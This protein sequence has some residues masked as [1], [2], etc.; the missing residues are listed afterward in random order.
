MNRHLKAPFVRSLLGI[1]LASK[2]LIVLNSCGVE[3]GNPSTKNPKP[4]SVD[5]VALIQD[6]QLTSSF[7]NASHGD[8]VAA[9]VDQASSASS[10]NF[11]LTDSDND[12]S[13]VDKSCAQS[14]DGRAA[15]V[16]VS[17][18]IDRS[19]TKSH[20]GGRVTISA[21]RTGTSNATRTWSRVDGTPVACNSNGSGANVNFK[22]IPNLK[23]NIAFERK[24]IDMITYDGPRVKRTASK[25]FTSSGNRSVTWI[26]NSSNE[27]TPTYIRS[28]SVAIR[29]VKQSLSMTNKN[30]ETFATEL[31]INTPAA[32]PLVVDV[33]RNTNTHAVVSKTFASGE[34][35]VNK[36]S[37]STIT[38]IYNNL[39]LNFSDNTCSISSGSA[40]I[41]IKDTSSEVL[42]IFTLSVD[43]NG[44]SSLKNS[45]GEEVEG[46]ALDPC[47]PEDLKL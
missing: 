41:V 5:V 22:D 37:D 8:A 15:I 43:A 16:S 6:P 2:I 35:I 26:A 11:L 45:T 14:S 39:K 33:E 13:T 12:N 7:I 29:D 28:K 19:R 20:A 1:V 47:D 4:P 32:S 36:D 34:V 17:A 42:Q 10:L 9:S 24:R 3:A 27:S 25:S 44:D 46:F 31:I 30:G 38:T 40:Q 18:N 23:L 21:S